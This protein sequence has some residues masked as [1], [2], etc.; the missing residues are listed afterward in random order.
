MR[1][2]LIALALAVMPAAA[3]AEWLE[4]SSPHFV[5][6]ADD[7][8]RDIRKFSEQLERYHHAMAVVTNAAD[9]SAPSP[10]NRVTVFVVRNEREI[11]RLIGMRNIG[12]FYLP[13]AGGSV[14]FVPEVETGRGQTDRSM[15]VLMHEYAHHFLISNSAF[16][17]PRWLGEGSAEFFSGA[18]FSSDGGLTLGLPMRD[19]YLEIAYALDVDVDE[20]LDPDLYE[21]N[22][23][24]GYDSFYGKSWALYH[25]LTF[26]P[27]RRGQLGNYLRGMA[28]GK[29]SREAAVAAFGDLADL[30]RDLDQ[31]LRRTRV[32]SM[33]FRAD[34][35]D[36]G[37]VDVRRLSPGEVA[38]LPAMIRSK[39]GVDSAEAAEV[40]VDARAVAAQYPGDAAVLAAL[41]EAEFDAGNDTEAIAAADAALAL[42]AGQANAYVQKGYAL[43]RRATTAEDRTAAYSAAIAPFLALNQ[44]ENDHPLPLFYFYRSFVE[45]GARPT[46]NAVQGLERAV[47]LAPF[48][49]GL[50]M[51]LATQQIISGELASAR[52]NLVPIAYNP[53]GRGDAVAAIRNVIAR[54]DLGGEPTT[55]ELLALL[56]PPAAVAAETPPDT[57][58]ESDTGEAGGAEGDG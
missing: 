37:Q 31:Y 45:R 42:D 44:I 24:A 7:S 54:I 3:Q 25:Y 58:S 27:E 13:R 36:A 18:R 1:C 39:R 20:L 40:L 41:A 51:T 22:G 57:A 16:P 23:R 43:F 35:L 4:A 17:I 52:E 26:D 14:A 10:S 6:V 50:R 19:S 12:G 49:L 29:T 5:V 33:V 34:Q 48:D 30:N 38:M 56:R 2:W 28:A 47:D 21:K 55:A 32:M 9:A 8:E 15:N 46:D 11:Q 53:H